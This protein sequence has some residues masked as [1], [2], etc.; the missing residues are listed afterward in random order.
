MEGIRKINN[1]ISNIR[2]FPYLFLVVYLLAISWANFKYGV[3]LGLDTIFILLFF[4]A[5][6]VGRLNTFLRD[7]IPF[8]LMFFGYEAMRGV[9]DNL[10]QSVHVFEMIKADIFLFGQIPTIFL[11]KHLWNPDHLAWYDVFSFFF[12]LSHFWF[13]FLVGFIIWL[14]KREY[15]KFF[16]WGFIIL[17]ALGFITYLLFPAMAPWDASKHG[18][19]SGVDR[20]LIEIG[21]KLNLGG[22]IT[23]VYRW[24]GPNQVAAVPSLH[25]AWAWFA[26][27]SLV[28]FFGK[29]L[30]PFFIIPLGLD[31]SLVYFGE[32]YVIDILIGILY[33]SFVFWLSVKLF[34][35]NNT[36]QPQRKILLLNIKK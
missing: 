29:K 7:W 23:V 4:A 26:V 5:I 19:I 13:I 25:A 34:K 30:A 3:A 36:H 32:H 1:F 21:K 27:L 6:I 28:L 35:I 33:A 9:A 11:Q 24:I 31:F 20:L 16:S 2:N 12:Y 8:V 18:Y 15:F 14:K 10:N 17:C 22:V